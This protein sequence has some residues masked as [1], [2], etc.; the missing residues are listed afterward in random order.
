[1][2]EG[3]RNK[4]HHGCLTVK[5]QRPGGELALCW[6]WVA[7]HLQGSVPLRIRG[8]GGSSEEPGTEANLRKPDAELLT[9][10]HNK[11]KYYFEKR[12][13]HSLCLCW[14]WGSLWH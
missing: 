12:R 11:A 10:K 1:V 4:V 8:F 5:K 9:A 2:A 6:G 13:L 7:I 14:V 3:L